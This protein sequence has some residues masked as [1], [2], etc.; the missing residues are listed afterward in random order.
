[1]GQLVG[2]A[3]ALYLAETIPF[4]GGPRLRER[5]ADDN[6]LQA[7]HQCVV[8]YAAQTERCDIASGRQ[9]AVGVA[10]QIED[11]D[12]FFASLG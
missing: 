3:D 6:P 9:G 10:L 4:V 12:L 8:A 7:Q 1:M 2:K 5:V 11:H